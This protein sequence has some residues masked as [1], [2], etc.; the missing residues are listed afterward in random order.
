MDT[1]LQSTG[2][3]SFPYS[4]PA[5]PRQP[6]EFPACPHFP[7]LGAQNW[8]WPPADPWINS[9]RFYPTVHHGG[10]AMNP[11][12]AARSL[13]KLPAYLP[14]RQANTQP[15]LVLSVLHLSQ[16]SPR[17]GTALDGGYHRKRH[18]ASW[19]VH[20]QP[21][22]SPS[23]FSFHPK[24]MLPPSAGGRPLPLPKSRGETLSTHRDFIKRTF[25]RIFSVVC[26]CG[27]R[28]WKTARPL[29][30]E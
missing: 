12:Q 22:R 17:T 5:R 1:E 3:P 13:V 30:L 6:G 14:C 27:V 15:H 8:R 29:Q 21:S 10:I 23:R 7:T 18:Q 2:L 26:L 19:P 20:R 9:W 11:R 16:F 24:N 4:P 25:S 28:S